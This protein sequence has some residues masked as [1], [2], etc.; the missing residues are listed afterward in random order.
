M[1][2]QPHTFLLI[3]GAHHGKWCWE[4]TQTHLQ[5]LGHQAIAHTL[6]G[7]AEKSGAL[8]AKLDISEM[9]DDVAE[10]LEKMNATEVILVGHSFG[11]SVI[12][13]LADRIPNRIARLIYLDAIWI[14]DNHSLFD[15]MPEEVVAT[16]RQS[17]QEQGN[18]LAFPPAPPEAFGIT[19][20][21][22]MQVMENNLT[23]HPLASY[24]TPLRLK[25][26]LRNGLA[27]DYILCTDPL[28][29]PLTEAVRRYEADNVPIHKI[30]GPHD[31]MLSHP[32]ETAEL[33]V[34]IAGQ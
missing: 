28:Y 19:Q 12:T 15:F 31:V 30:A 27:A 29:T 22:L 32:K 14:E 1:T 34:K 8:H 6:P 33:L 11:G 7:L 16:R 20:P 21:D 17:A 13:A 5:H 3:H 18:G 24:E 26:P 9:A 2:S 4:Q 25:N 23:P 10:A